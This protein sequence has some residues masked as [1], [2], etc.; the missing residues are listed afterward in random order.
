MEPD[1]LHNKDV[2]AARI[3]ECRDDYDFVREDMEDHLNLTPTQ[4]FGIDLLCDMASALMVAMV[5]VMRAGF[6]PSQLA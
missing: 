4:W 1:C 2:L 3:K 5:D 6:E